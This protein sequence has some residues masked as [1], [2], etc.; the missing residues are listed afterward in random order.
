M[1]KKLGETNLTDEQIS[2][3]KEAFS[4]FDKIALL[5]LVEL[6]CSF[7]LPPK[8]TIPL[9]DLQSLDDLVSFFSTIPGLISRRQSPPT[10]GRQLLLLSPSSFLGSFVRKCVV[11]FNNLSLD[12][13]IRLWKTAIVVREDIVK[14]L[15]VLLKENNSMLIKENEQ[16]NEIQKQIDHINDMK[17][18]VEQTITNRLE[19]SEDENSTLPITSEKESVFKEDPVL[20]YENSNAIKTDSG[21]LNLETIPIL[22]DLKNLKD[23][24]NFEND[25]NP[26]IT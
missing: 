24:S 6:Y 1:V 20:L 4:L 25:S 14:Q 13:V 3:F 5:V 17:Q 2:E 11:E 15:E 12:D 10:V 21:V 16:L 9:W 22:K 19:T 8:H 7:L 23:I 26:E 18:Q